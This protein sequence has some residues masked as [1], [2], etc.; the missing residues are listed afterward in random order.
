LAE[1]EPAVDLDPLSPAIRST[2]PNWYY[3]NGEFDRA[4]TE[5]RKIIAA[6]PD[7]PPIRNVLTMCYFLKGDY[8]QALTE[9]DATRL[10]QPQ[11]PLFCIELRGYALARLGQN[12]EVQ[13]ILKELDAEKQQGRPVD[14]AIGFVYLGLRDYD[15]ALDA[16]EPDV[17]HNGLPEEFFCDPFL[18]EVRNLPRVQAWLKKAENQRATF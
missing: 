8:A 10:L 14:S 5:C 6:F 2:I 7:F 11:D 18:N 12:D 3:I 4:I 17:T 13:R 9:I 1:F 16:F 15:K